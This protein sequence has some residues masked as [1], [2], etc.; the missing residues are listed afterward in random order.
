MPDGSWK[1]IMDDMGFPAGLQRTIVVDLTGKL[2]QGTRHIRM[3]TNLQIYWDQVLID[4]GPEWRGA[5]DGVAARTAHLAFRGYPQQS[6]WRRHPA[7]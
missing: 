7:T 5:H 1:R 3:K 4:N 6:R 2:P